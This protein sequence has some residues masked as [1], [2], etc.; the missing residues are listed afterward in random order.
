[1]KTKLIAG[2]ICVFTL[3]L[4]ADLPKS[5]MP[6]AGGSSLTAG[7]DYS[8][9]PIRDTYAVITG[10]TCN[11]AATG[12]VGHPT[13]SFYDVLVCDGSAWDH[14]I[15]GRE[16]TPPV[17]AN[18][19]WVNQGSSTVSTTNG[20]VVLTIPASASTAIRGRVMTAPATPYN[21]EMCAYAD[22][23]SANFA[24]AGFLGWSSGGSAGLGFYVTQLGTLYQAFITNTTTF[25]A[26]IG[27]PVLR[28]MHSA[29][30]CVKYEDN[31]TN[32]ILYSSGNGG[33]TWTQTFSGSRTATVTIDQFGF[34]GNTS[35]SD[36]VVI[37]VV[38]FK[39]S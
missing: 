25:G 24:G 15:N 7:A 19:S 27:T 17:D 1:M 2:L 34:F 18:F 32:R 9:V 29:L 4:L 14:F 21:V 12:Q 39:V 37:T 5:S 35:N 26:D 20:G 28:R 22:M 33:I 36:P 3:V 10:T 31:G 38:H 11:A 6:P 13:N 30:Q 16:V 8:K 23:D